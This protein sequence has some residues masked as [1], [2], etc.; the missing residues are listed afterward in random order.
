ML[1]KRVSSVLCGALLAMSLTGCAS[2]INDASEVIH[3]KIMK[4]IEEEERKEELE[5]M[6]HFICAYCEQEMR[7]DSI[8][9]VT[10]PD[11]KNVYLCNV[12]RYVDCKLDYLRYNGYLDYCCECGA[13]TSLDNQ[14]DVYNENTLQMTCSDCITAKL[15]EEQYKERH[16][17][18]YCGREMEEIAPNEYKCTSTFCASSYWH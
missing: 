10:L 3:N 6:N 2:T 5:N 16:N 15:I 14:N 12:S 4:S 8:E 7:E 9:L 11:G 17:C 13:Q 18:I 1:F